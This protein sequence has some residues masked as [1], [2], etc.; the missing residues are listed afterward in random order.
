MTV[1]NLK[2]GRA[3]HLGAILVPHDIFKYVTTNAGWTSTIGTYKPA[4]RQTYLN[5]IKY[6]MDTN[7]S[8][9]VRSQ[10][11]SKFAAIQ[12]ITQCATIVYGKPHISG[13]TLTVATPLTFAISL[14][15]ATGKAPSTAALTI[16]A[17]G[18]PGLVNGYTIDWGDSS[19]VDQ[20]GGAETRTKS[21]AF[22]TIGVRTITVTATHNGVSTG[23]SH[24]LTFTA[25]A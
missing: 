20:I 4:S 9:V 16:T 1:P 11:S 23:L 21:H 5:S 3:D 10:S 8:C 12:D 25:T 22:T 14:D 2:P 18:T 7:G 17:S 13:D 15:I 6:W 19:I 24:T